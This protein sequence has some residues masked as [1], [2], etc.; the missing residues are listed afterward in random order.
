MKANDLTVTIRA[1]D[2]ASPVLSRLSRRLWWFQ[3]G[4]GILFGTSVFL[5]VL[6]IVLTFVLG[7]LTA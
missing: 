5:M 3:Y 6:V 4:G 1:V 2:E 7:R